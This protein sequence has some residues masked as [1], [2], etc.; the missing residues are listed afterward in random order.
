M[1]CGQRFEE[2]NAPRVRETRPKSTSRRISP[3]S[4]RLPTKK[5][6][7]VPRYITEVM[8]IHPQAGR[9]EWLHGI[10]QVLRA[11]VVVEMK[12]AK[13][14][15]ITEASEAV[16]ARGLDQEAFGRVSYPPTDTKRG[17]FFVFHILYSVLLPHSDKYG[18]DRARAVELLE[19]G[20]LDQM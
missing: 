20:H 1:F 5:N 6:M 4:H 13:T 9:Q 19:L 2:K 14:Q 15:P 10:L 11:G 12:A 7:R 17:I 3:P 8:Q 16:Q 18:L